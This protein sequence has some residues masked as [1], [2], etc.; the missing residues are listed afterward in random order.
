MKKGEAAQFDFGA[1]WKA[2]SER[3]LT[4]ARVKQAQEHFVALFR[5]VDLRD[6]TFLDVGF[7]QGL[8]LLAATAQGARTVGCDIDLTCAQVLD[9][10]RR[11]YFPQ[12]P[13]DR[14]S[15]VTGSILDEVV[16]ESLRMHAPVSGYDIVHSWGVLHHTGDMSQAIRN[17]ASLVA[18]G[19][20]LVVSLY[21]HHWSSK[22]WLFVKR[23]YNMSPAVLRP[24]YIWLF[25]P[26]IYIAKWLVTRRSPLEQTRGMD[27][28][29]DVVDWIGGYPYEYATVKAVASRIEALGFDIV[30]VNPASVPTG[31]N[32]FICR[33]RDNRTTSLVAERLD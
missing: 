16:I 21:T 26:I 17:V 20:H 31:C 28:H 18:P 2:F 3:A 14:I 23:L 9:E 8:T 12:L 22:L 11:R 19:G 25:W 5:G 24:F 32:E 33:R 4:A 30:R 1:N 27:F 7:G 15:I 29:Y 10:N 6:R 13:E